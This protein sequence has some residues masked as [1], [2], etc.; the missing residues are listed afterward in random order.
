MSRILT[1][2][3]WSQVR[4]LFHPQNQIKTDMKRKKII[5]KARELLA[6][7][8]LSE[9]AADAIKR[10]F[11]ELAESEDERI[12]MALISLVKEIKSQSLVRLEPWDKYIAY[13]EKKEQKPIKLDDDTEVGLDRALQIVKDAKGNLCGYQSDD[14]I[15]ECDHAIQT[16]ERILKNGIEQQPVE[17]SEEDEK[18]YQSI[19]DDTVQENQLNDKQTN[20]LRDIKYRYF[21]QS[22]QEWSENEEEVDFFIEDVKFPF[23]AKEKSTGKIVTITSGTENEDGASYVF[24]WSGKNRYLPE[25][26]L[27]YN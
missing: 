17:W 7:G 5:K 11:P 23:K 9:D 16:L 12:R 10:D 1:K 3:Q 22:K 26:L 6:C 8:M 27:K 21:P 20:W 19:M 24:F 4:I 18:I 13:L 25:D 14:G 15:Y 2:Y